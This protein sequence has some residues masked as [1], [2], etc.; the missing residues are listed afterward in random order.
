MSYSD[1][2][3]TETWYGTCIHISFVLWG[4]VWYMY[5]YLLCFV[6]RGMVHVFISSWGYVVRYSDLL[7]AMWY[8][9]H[10]FL[11]LCG[12]VFISSWGYVVRYSDLLE[13]M[14]YGIQIFLRLCGTVFISSW[15][16]V[17]RYWDLLEAMWYGIQIFLGNNV[18]IRSWQSKHTCS[19]LTSHSSTSISALLHQPVGYNTE[20][21]F[22][23][24]S[25][26]SSHCFFFLQLTIY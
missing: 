13:A 12:T 3:K 26:A 1:L 14:W 23:Q 17:V 4:L 2:Y 11:R 5:S 19:W 8:G 7:E 25:L 24:W 21:E 6:R 20:Q 10:I 18:V 15:G 22:Q 9:I 16:Y